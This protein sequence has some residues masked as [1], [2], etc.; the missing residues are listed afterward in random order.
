MLHINR[1]KAYTLDNIIKRK[2]KKDS[3]LLEN[4]AIRIMY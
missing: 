3:N 2:I 1:S 4:F